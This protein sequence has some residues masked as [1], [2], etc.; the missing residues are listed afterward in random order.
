MGKPLRTID[1]ADSTDAGREINACSG[2]RVGCFASDAGGTPASTDGYFAAKTFDTS[3]WKRGS[4]RNG[5]SIGSTLINA[6]S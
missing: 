6:I 1:R 3:A 5:S 4:P 2:S